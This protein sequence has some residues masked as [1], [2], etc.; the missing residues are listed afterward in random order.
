MIAHTVTDRGSY[1]EVTLTEWGSAT[2]LD[3]VHACY[4][5]VLGAVILEPEDRRNA[6]TWN[7][8]AEFRF[9]GD[10]RYLAE[11]WEEVPD[12]LVYDPDR[13]NQTSEYLR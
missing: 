1:E 10:V 12:T 6:N 3:A 8:D 13:D 2:N 7:E 9:R 5:D 4:G 11:A